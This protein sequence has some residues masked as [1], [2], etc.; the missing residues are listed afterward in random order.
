MKDF[1]RQPFPRLRVPQK[2]LLF[3]KL[4]HHRTSGHARLYNSSVETIR[5]SL[6][7]SLSN[8]PRYRFWWALIPLARVKKPILANSIVIKHVQ[9]DF[10]TPISSIL[11]KTIHRSLLSYHHPP[12]LKGKNH[13]LCRSSDWFGCLLWFCTRAFNHCLFPL[14]KPRASSSGEKALFFTFTKQFPL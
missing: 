13:F 10:V 3:A 11:S 1:S 14:I 2:S 5:R 12:C 9:C 6:A 7:A 4:W 8:E